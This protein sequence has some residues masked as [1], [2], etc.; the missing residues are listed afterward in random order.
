MET[1]CG[2]LRQLN[3]LFHNVIFPCF[4][5]IERILFYFYNHTKYLPSFD[6]INTDFCR[7]KKTVYISLPFVILFE[8]LSFAFSII[9]YIL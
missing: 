6:K 5:I 1:S 2:T 4:E 9:S 8:L 3:L 7:D